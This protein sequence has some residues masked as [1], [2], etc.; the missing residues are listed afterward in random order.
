MLLVNLTPCCKKK[1]MKT[2]NPAAL[3]TQ[4]D[5]KQ[6]IITT[7]HIIVSLQD[8]VNIVSYIKGRNSK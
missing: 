2:Y 8:T 7:C 5:N 6:G 1:G 4:G 3:C